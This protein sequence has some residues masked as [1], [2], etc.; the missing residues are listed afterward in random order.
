MEL[1]ENSPIIPARIVSHGDGRKEVE[2]P[3]AASIAGAD[4]LLPRAIF[5]GIDPVHEPEKRPIPDEH[6]RSILKKSAP[7]AVLGDFRWSG[8]MHFN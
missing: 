6:G 3:D 8:N 1:V 2:H 5:V 4:R 7:D